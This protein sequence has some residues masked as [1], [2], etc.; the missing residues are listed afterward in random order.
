[1][2]QCPQ[3]AERSETQAGGPRPVTVSEDLTAFVARHRVPGYR[4]PAAVLEV[5]E[6][7]PTRYRAYAMPDFFASAIR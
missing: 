7:A 3:E 2:L 6:T 5:A 1:M 4:G